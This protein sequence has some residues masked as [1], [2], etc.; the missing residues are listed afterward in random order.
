MPAT[1]AAAESDFSARKLTA[2][3]AILIG[4]FFGSTVLPFAAQAPFI[5][6]GMLIAPPAMA[7]CYDRL[8]T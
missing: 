6:S 4:V 8:G 7:Y 1:T 2:A 5:A 3:L